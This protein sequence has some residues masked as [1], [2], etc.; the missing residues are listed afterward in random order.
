M[1]R[2][3]EHVRTIGRTDAATT[4]RAVKVLHAR[5]ITG[6]HSVRR[7]TT[8]SVSSKEMH[9]TIATRVAA[10]VFSVKVISGILPANKKAT[11]RITL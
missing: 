1:S 8:H 2:G 7:I 4:I 11:I 6:V 3:A 10:A 9:V 5:S